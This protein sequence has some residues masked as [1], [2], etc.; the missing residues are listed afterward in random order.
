M[1]IPGCSFPHSRSHVVVLLVG[2]TTTPAEGRK[3]TLIYT[4][5]GDGRGKIWG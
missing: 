1:L 5:V 3:K 2:N 4:P